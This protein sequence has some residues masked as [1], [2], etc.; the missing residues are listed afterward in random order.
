MKKRAKYRIGAALFVV[1]L[2][3]CR[4]FRRLLGH[5]GLQLPLPAGRPQSPNPDDRIAVLHPRAEVTHCY[6]GSRIGCDLD[7]RSSC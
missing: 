1:A 7:I 2:I 5:S 3:F 6:L 4:I